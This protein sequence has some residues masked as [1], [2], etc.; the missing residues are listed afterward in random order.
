GIE[1]YKYPVMG[2]NR[3]RHREVIFNVYSNGLNTSRDSYTWNLSKEK[4]REYMERLIST[5]NQH[6]ERYNKGELT[7]EDIEN[8]R[9]IELDERKIKWDDTLRKEIMKNK[10]YTIENGGKFYNGI[11]RPFISQYVYFSKV[12]N[13]RV[14]QLPKVFPYPDAK[15]LVI[16]VSN[17]AD[18]F[19][20][21]MVNRL[22]DFHLLQGNSLG[23][24]L[25]VYEPVDKGQGKLFSS[26]KDSYNRLSNISDYAL[27]EYRKKYGKDISYEDIFY[28]VFGMLNNPNYQNKFKNE[29]M[30]EIPRIPF[31]KDREKFEKIRDIGKQIADLQI[32]YE[33]LPFYEELKITIY[34]EDYEI[35]RMRIDRENKKLVYNDHIIIENIPEEAFNYKI[36]GKSPIEWVVNRYKYVYDEKTDT[37]LDPNDVLKEKGNDY[38]LNLIRRLVYL[39]VEILKLKEE[40][41]NYY[42]NN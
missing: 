27:Q 32:N 35:Q 25:Y 38:V 40:L 23:F 11:Y 30:R 26:H 42:L 24:P 7:R 31:V 9:K 34:K 12:F 36:N 28:Y 37:I 8:K 17:K 33:T 41:G 1:F 18:D 15:N 16:V 39:S 6:V 22:F 4:L 19:D 29:L 5:F 3:N 10:M 2:D 13:N 20:V 14:Y 21:M